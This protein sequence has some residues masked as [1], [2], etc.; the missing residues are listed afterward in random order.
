MVTILTVFICLRA[1]C[2]EVGPVPTPLGYAC[3]DDGWLKAYLFENY[4]RWTYKMFR[5]ESGR[6][7]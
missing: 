7:I 2:M 1:M 4:P 6:F 3:D 5:C